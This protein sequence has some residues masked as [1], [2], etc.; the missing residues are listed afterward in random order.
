VTK[1]IDFND[2]EVTINKT[3]KQLEISRQAA[4]EH[5]QLISVQRDLTIAA[6]IQQSILPRKFPPF[7]DRKEID[8]YGEMHPAKDVGGDFF[9]FFFVDPDNLGFVIGDVS[10]KGIPAAI[11]MAQSRTV[12]RTIGQR[13]KEPGELLRE[14]NQSLIPES[15]ET[16]FV[17]IF[18]GLLN[19]KTGELTYSIGGHNPPFLVG[20]AGTATMLEY[21]GGGI[22]GKIPGLPFDSGKIRLNPGDT[23][24]MYTDGVTE[25]ANREG[26]FFEEARVVESLQKCRHLSVKEMQSH[27]A[28]DL[29][30][31]TD[32]APQSDDITIFLLRYVGFDGGNGAAVAGS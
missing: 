10:G 12:L 31:F 18:Y 6:R 1:P 29:K 8:L 19:T 2:L 17:T 16:T 28:A 3:L 4:M 26:T 11:F 9:D 23:L 32:G 13:I 27:V 14:V 5:E 25:A 20:S 7:P 15:D 30:A 22:V 21:A 24:F